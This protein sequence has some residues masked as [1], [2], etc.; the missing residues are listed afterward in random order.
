MKILHRSPTTVKVGAPRRSEDCRECQLAGSG[1][2]PAED[3][4]G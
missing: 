4:Q 1:A 2:F 3:T